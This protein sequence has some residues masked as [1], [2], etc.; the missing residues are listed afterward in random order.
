MRTVLLAGLCLAGCVATP[1]PA[2]E[3]APEPVV[4]QP[5]DAAV[6]GTYDKAAFSR[7]FTEIGGYSIVSDDAGTMVLQ[8]NGQGAKIVLE[9]KPATAPQARPPD[10]QSWEPG[11]YWS[12]MMRAKDIPSIV[13]DARPLGWEPRTEVAYLEFGPSQLNIVVLT[14]QATGAQVQLYER[15]TTP[16]PEGYPKFERFG[17][18]FNIMQMS[19]DRDATY[20]FFTEEL[21]FA[22]FYHG[23][24][25]VSDKPEVMPLG[26]P[27]ELTTTVPYRASIVSPEPG[28]ETGRFEM[29]EVMG[30]EAGLVGRNFK[31]RCSAA[32]VGLTRVEYHDVDL[33]A[34]ERAI[35]DN[36]GEYGVVVQR[37]PRA[38]EPQEIVRTVVAPDGAS[39][40][41]GSPL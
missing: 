38:N 31:D 15:L 16:L 13:E 36:T 35:G 7:L 14:H 12:L 41:F 9:E 29:I 37:L 4:T 26:I 5:W 11:C 2:R 20:R 18:P 8:Q 32:A 3:Q 27:V 21:G 1:G 30:A 40:A 39:I 22:T 19:S 17:V 34:W 23:E 24:P 25:S 10:A 6:F 33:A 28:M